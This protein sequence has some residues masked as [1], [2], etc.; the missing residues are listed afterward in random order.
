MPVRPMVLRGERDV[1]GTADIVRSRLPQAVQV[2]LENSGHLHW[3]QNEA[4][5]RQALR[6]FY[7]P[8]WR[9]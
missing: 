6:H 5:Y 2:T 9:G 3:L 4:G 8:H 7:S 1:F